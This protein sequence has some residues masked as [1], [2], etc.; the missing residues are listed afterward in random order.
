MATLRAV[1]RI[2]PQDAALVALGRTL[3][4]IIDAAEEPVT[5]VGYAYLQVL[6]G[7]RGEVTPAQDGDDL[8][9]FLAVLSAQ[10][11]DATK[12]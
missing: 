8:A 7:L 12:P 2:E 6:R 3:A 4:E 10:V 11:G 5:Q 1:G 9:A